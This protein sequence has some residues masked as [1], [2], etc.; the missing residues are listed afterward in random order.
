[1]QTILW[2][3]DSLHSVQPGQAKR[4][5]SQA[6][7]LKSACIWGLASRNMA[8]NVNPRGSTKH[9]RGSA[10]FQH[11]KADTHLPEHPHTRTGTDAHLGAAERC[12]D[13]PSPS[14]HR[15]ST[16]PGKEHALPLYLLIISLMRLF[17]GSLITIIETIPFSTL[18]TAQNRRSP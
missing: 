2:F 1:M 10:L 6:L 5:D 8:G 12:G 4:L 16:L 18:F 9:S 14:G 11:Q 17:P 3:Y 7:R 13:K 15:A